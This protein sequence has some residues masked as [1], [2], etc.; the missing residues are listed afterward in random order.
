MTEYALGNVFI[1]PFRLEGAG[2]VMAGHTHNFDHVTYVVRGSVHARCWRRILDADGSPM[3]SATGEEMWFLFAERDVLAGDL[4]PIRA[5][6]KH[7]FTALEPRTLCH[8]IYSHRDPQS[9]EVIQDH[10][11]WIDAYV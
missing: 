7:G 8:C 4:V 3:V 6:D 11:G 5:E 2:D 1:R 9:H 10:N